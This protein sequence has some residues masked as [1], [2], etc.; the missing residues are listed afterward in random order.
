MKTLNVNQA[1]Q[2]LIDHHIFWF[3]YLDLKRIESEAVNLS[4]KDAAAR[5]CHYITRG[6]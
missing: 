5:L 3:S 6:R 2:I 1:R 4:A